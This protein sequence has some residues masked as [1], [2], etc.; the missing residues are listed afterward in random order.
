[1]DPCEKERNMKMICHCEREPLNENNQ[2][3]TAPN[4]TFRSAEC[5]ILKNDLTLQDP[6]WKAFD[7]YS[8]MSDLKFIVQSGSLDFLP[9]MIFKN[10][11]HLVDIAVMYSNINTV[12]GFAFANLSAVHTIRLNNNNHLKSLQRNAFANHDRLRRLD[13]EKNDIQQIDR[14]A[15]VNLFSLE[16][17]ALNHNNISEIRNGTFSGLQSLLELQLQHNRIVEVTSVMFH[18]LES[19]RVLKLSSNKIQFV[20]NA[21]FT[22]LWSLQELYLDNNHIEVRTTGRS[23][24]FVLSGCE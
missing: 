17:L 16:Y 12:E 18:R 9:T 13:V 11:I 2:Q 22:E 15:F 8:G 5:W 20:G 14:H 24:A 10:M 19:L 21:A 4:Q 3:S 23:L 6:L 7:R 1:M